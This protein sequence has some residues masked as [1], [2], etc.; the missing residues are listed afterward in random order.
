MY[1]SSEIPKYLENVEIIQYNTIL[2]LIMCAQSTIGWNLIQKFQNFTEN[3][4]FEGK[5]S[6]LWTAVAE[7]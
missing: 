7:K 1:I 4:R 5:L 6:S 2:A 3:C